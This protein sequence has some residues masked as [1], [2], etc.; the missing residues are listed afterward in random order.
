MAE[1]DD[2]GF[3]WAAEDEV[4]DCASTNVEDSPVQWC[5]ETAIPIV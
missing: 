3:G 2:K 5:L 4:S 1:H